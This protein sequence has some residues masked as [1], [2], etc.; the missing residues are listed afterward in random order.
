MSTVEEY[1]AAMNELAAASK[2]YAPFNAYLMKVREAVGYSGSSLEFLRDTFGLKYEH[3]N[4]HSMDS[5]HRLNLKEWPSAEA[6]H[7]AGT[8]LAK[9]YNNAHSTYAGLPAE[10]R[11]YVKSPPYHVDMKIS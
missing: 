11:E 10:D 5:K 7:E 3:G 1:K 6:L 8:R 9:A 2:A 4:R